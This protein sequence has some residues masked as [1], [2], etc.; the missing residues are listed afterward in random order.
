MGSFKKIQDNE[1]SSRFIQ[2]RPLYDK[3]LKLIEFKIEDK[4][5]V[6]EKENLK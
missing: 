6:I 1:D 3:E 5:V 2:I 4:K